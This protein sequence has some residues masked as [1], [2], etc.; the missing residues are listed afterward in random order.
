MLKPT[1]QMQQ[2]EVTDSHEEG[3][4]AVAEPAKPEE[5]EKDSQEVEQVVAGGE[6]V[7]MTEVTQEQACTEPLV[8]RDEGE[9]QDED[10]EGEP[11]AT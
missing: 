7:E 5:Q 11:V 6:D 2:P 8:E 9:T 3:K 10:N 1:S 4:E